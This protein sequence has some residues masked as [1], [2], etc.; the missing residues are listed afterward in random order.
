MCYLP[1]TLY[2]RSNL[3]MKCCVYTRGGK[4]GIEPTPL[5]APYT[6]LASHIYTTI[7]N[8]CA[9]LYRFLSKSQVKAKTLRFRRVFV[10]GFHDLDSRLVVEIASRIYIILVY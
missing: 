4:V 1:K 9:V 6:P 3:K 7:G 2:A 10:R 5:Y 8:L